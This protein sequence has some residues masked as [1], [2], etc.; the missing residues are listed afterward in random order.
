[1]LNTLISE[2]MLDNCLVKLNNK[3]I[4][5]LNP[6]LII[7]QKLNDKEVSK[8][9]ELHVEQYQIM[10]EMEFCH[11]S[12]QSKLKELFKDWVDNQYR[13][14]DTWGFTRDSKMHKFWILPHCSCPKADNE[15]EYPSSD[16]WVDKKCIIHG[17]R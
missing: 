17:T 15:S 16:Y 5:Q 7:Q 9:K 1:M 8:L 11:K 3:I 14:Q 2:S 12:N 10:K 13:L 6:S 4:T